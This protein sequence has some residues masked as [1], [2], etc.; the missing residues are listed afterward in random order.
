MTIE[1]EN[2]LRSRLVPILQKLDP[3]KPPRWGKM[4]LQQMI[5]HYTSN[6][7]CIASGRIK[8]NDIITPP[9]RLVRYREFMMSERPFQENTM[10][11]LLPQEPVA[12][13]HKTVQ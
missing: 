8:V 4:S 12:V 13:A 6:G 3:S 1:K 7:L 2:F 11:P 10:N 9:D 5:E